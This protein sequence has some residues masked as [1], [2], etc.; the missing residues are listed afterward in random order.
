MALKIAPS[1]LPRG[2]PKLWKKHLEVTKIWMNFFYL[3]KH[4]IADSWVKFILVSPLLLQIPP[5][6][7]D[8]SRQSV[9]LRCN[10]MNFVRKDLLR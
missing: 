5:L 10:M 7:V 2:A 3:C 8:A 9:D 4:H 6:D 1:S